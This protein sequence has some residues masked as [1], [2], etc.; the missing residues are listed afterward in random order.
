MQFINNWQRP[1]VLGEL[2][3]SA[4]LDLPDGSYRLTISNGELVEIVDAEVTSGTAALQRG[5][6]GTTPQ[7]WPEGSVIYA[8]VTAE[9]YRRMAGLSGE[10]DPNGV[11][12]ANPAALYFD[13]LTFAPWVCE[14]GSSWIRLEI[15]QDVFPVSGGTFDLIAP[16]NGDFVVMDGV[17]VTL[18]APVV[19][20]NVP[21][22]GSPLSMT[23]SG[24]MLLSVRSVFGGG[25]TL[26]ATPVT[27]YGE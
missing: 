25:L 17:V 22:S 27:A 6:E 5:V 12:T 20:S 21:L 15:A 24:A 18:N 4:A 16:V 7:E 19:H 11:V 13:T 1:I 3:D 14:M 23:A 10:G 2:E 8:S 9:M 26:L